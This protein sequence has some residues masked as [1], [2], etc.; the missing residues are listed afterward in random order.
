[1]RSIAIGVF[2]IFMS[3][4]AYSEGLKTLGC[5]DCFNF[6][7]PS[8]MGA[9]TLSSPQVGLIVFDQN[10]NKFR[11]YAQSGAWQSLSN[12]DA[13]VTKTSSYT[14][15]ALDNV[16]LGSGTITITL[17]AASGLPGKVYKIRNIGSPGFVT[18]GTSGADTI[19]G[20]ASIVLGQKFDEVEVSSSGSSWQIANSRIAATRT[21]YQA[22]VT[23]LTYLTP[24]GVRYL[25]IR[26]SGGGGGGGGSGSGAGTGTAG[27]STTFGSILSANGGSGGGS[28]SASGT[29]GAGGAATVNTGATG[30]ATTGG[31]GSAGSPVAGAA[32][33]LGG[34]GGINVFVGGGASVSGA[35]AAAK[36]NTGGGG[37]GAGGSSTSV[38]PGN[39]G[40]A[41]GYVDALINS[42]ATSYTYSIG[43][44]GSGGS[45][46][47]S[48]FAGGAGGTGVIIIDEYY[49]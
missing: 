46:G 28:A 43:A 21:V 25:K 18:V 1:M 22:V 23:G 14:A 39:G 6:S 4:N 8:V 17:P 47:T 35:G 31:T 5:L 29:G 15:A 30:I 42:P 20:F 3:F 11:A 26:M 10:V 32:N 48:G 2:T 27:G 41:G 12:D 37:G 38:Q 34:M 49:Q 45:S 33:S 36:S 7:A 16:I 9:E 40:G 19:D 24:P 44:G 13:V